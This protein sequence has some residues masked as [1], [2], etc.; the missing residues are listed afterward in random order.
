MRVQMELTLPREARYVAMM[1]EVARCVL[2]QLDTP[3]EAISDVQLAVTEAC[4][5]AVRHA[6]G[7]AAYWVHVD[8]GDG[9]CDI[10]ITDTGPGFDPGSG[11]VSDDA[12]LDTGVPDATDLERESG[13]GLLLIGALVDDLEV[14]RDGEC[15]SVRLTKRFEAIPEPATVTDGS[16]ADPR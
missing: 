7:T 3:P 2:D 14:T 10:E 15:N 8:V 5:N 1:R 16:P 11:P 6:V 4:A 12:E 9:S 13:R